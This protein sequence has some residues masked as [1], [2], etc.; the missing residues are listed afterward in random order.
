M[1]AAWRQKWLP[2]MQVLL[3]HIITPPQRTLARQDSS[4]MHAGL[5]ASIRS[6]DTEC[7]GASCRFLTDLHQWTG[8]RR[9]AFWLL[10]RAAPAWHSMADM[11]VYGSRWA[12][13]SSKRLHGR[14]RVHGWVRLPYT[15]ALEFRAQPARFAARH[16]PD[17]PS[18][19][20]I[21][22]VTRK[23]PSP[24]LVSGPNITAAS[25]Y[26]L[27]LALALVFRL[28][29]VYAHTIRTSRRGQRRSHKALRP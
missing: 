13:P 20:L 9:A 5:L 8:G 16:T 17:P 14:L 11:E 3:F 29:V 23:P 24:R 18:F 10:T 26:Y 22:R 27:A 12:S 15:S 6:S 4:R 7:Q 19:W 25:Q 21:T 2:L 1:V 28:R